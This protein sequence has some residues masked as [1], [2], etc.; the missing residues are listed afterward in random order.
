MRNAD[1]KCI[2]GLDMLILQGVASFEIWNNVKVNKNIIQKVR[3]LLVEKLRE[4]MK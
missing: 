3:L 2:N 4:R 1:K